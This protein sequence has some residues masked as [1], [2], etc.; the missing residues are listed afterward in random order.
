MFL[1][2]VV[3]TLNI[4]LVVKFWTGS[5]S[6]LIPEE[7]IDK[8]RSMGWSTALLFLTPAMISCLEQMSERRVDQSM[9]YMDDLLSLLELVIALTHVYLF[10]RIIF[11]CTDADK[12][13][14]TAR[15]RGG[16]SGNSY[17]TGQESQYITKLIVCYS[18][19]PVALLGGVLW[20]WMSPDLLEETF[21]TALRVDL[22][23]RV[24]MAIGVIYYSWK[25]VG[26]MELITTLPGPRE[27]LLLVLWLYPLVG[28]V[29]QVLFLC[30]L[31]ETVVE[32]EPEEFSEAV[33]VEPLSKVLWQSDNGMIETVIQIQLLI[34]SLLYWRAWSTEHIREA[35]EQK[36]LP[37]E[38]PGNR[39]DGE[40][41]T[42]WEDVPYEEN[43]GSVELATGED[44]IF[45]QLLVDDY[46]E[47][48]YENLLDI[49]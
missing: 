49:T 23:F 20:K 43:A 17:I 9:D 26:I 4:A 5:A 3:A 41:S 13:S 28:I 47:I 24:S 33:T 12:F 6:M 22:V 36:L 35:F 8:F 2:I 19:G 34:I 46:P 32:L 10:W 30:T 15:V 18:Y 40:E 1:S 31:T 48:A 11:I 37:Q 45:G 21:L 27:K 38:T 42:K 14:E 16:D 44:K 25:I 29:R 39:S 7:N